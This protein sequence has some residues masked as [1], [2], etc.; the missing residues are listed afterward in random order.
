M[1]RFETRVS[2]KMSYTLRDSNFSSIYVWQLEKLGTWKLFDTWKPT[3]LILGKSS[4]ELRFKSY[5]QH[6]FIIFWI[7]SSFRATTVDLKFNS[8]DKN[9]QHQIGCILMYF[10]CRFMVSVK[11]YTGILIRCILPKCMHIHT[12]T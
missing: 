1:L 11:N 2:L 8:S 4:S 9:F 12:Y 5:F 6:L 3:T 10:I 7:K